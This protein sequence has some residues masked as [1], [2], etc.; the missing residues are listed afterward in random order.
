[1]VQPIHEDDFID[2]VAAALERDWVAAE[3]LVLAGPEP[4][5][6]ADF[7]RAVARAAGLRTPLV[8]PVPAAAL[9]ALAP[10]T[11][12][13]RFLPR[14]DADE[15]RRLQEDRAFPVDAMISRLG[16]RPIGLAEGLARTFTPP[17]PPAPS[18][19]RE[20]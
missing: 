13:L 8:L 19:P 3:T 5:R 9:I 4:V 10:L 17:V 1:L 16:V 14:L 20:E 15:V 18:T 11:A 12:R 2:C 6:Y 7:V